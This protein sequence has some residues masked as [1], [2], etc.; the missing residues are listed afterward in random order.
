M[1]T[2]TATVTLADL[3]RMLRESAGEEEG[4]DLDGDVI[5]TP[6][7]ELGY[8]SLALLQVIGQIQR[9]YGIEIPDDAVV[10]AETPGALLALINSG[11][12]TAA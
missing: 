4:I 9:E 10:D 8:D 12:A 11:R 7:M 5:D 3:T 2:T 6:F 1:S